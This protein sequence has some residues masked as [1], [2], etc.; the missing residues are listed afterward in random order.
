MSAVWQDSFVEE[1][2]LAKQIS[3]LRKIFNADGEN[4]IETL[5][6]HDYRFSADISQIFKPAEETIL[7]KHT[8]RKLTVRVEEDFDETPRLLPA[9]KRGLLNQT[10]FALL[11]LAVLL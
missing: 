9:A 1:D 8:I 3:R 7:E 10:V 4:L 6:K 2:N 11:G 5:P